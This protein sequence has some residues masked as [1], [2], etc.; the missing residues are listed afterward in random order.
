GFAL[1]LAV[2]IVGYVVFAWVSE[3]G[4]ARAADR[5]GVAVPR[6][7]LSVVGAFAALGVVFGGFD[8]SAVA[9]AEQSGSPV[10]AG[11]LIG[12]FALASVIAG[13]ILGARPAVR[14]RASRFVI[15]AMAYTLVVPF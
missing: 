2:G 11:L 7:V 15:T 12:L 8:I 1:G 5:T 10:A 3:S 14:S 4:G 9:L 6:S 13:T